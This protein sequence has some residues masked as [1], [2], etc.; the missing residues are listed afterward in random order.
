[1][2][3]TRNMIAEGLRRLGVRPGEVLLL[4]S[5][6]KSLGRV[7]GGPQ[8]LV[9]A[10]QDVLTTEGTLV[11]PTLT[12][13][14]VNA[15][16][17]RFDVRQSASRV[18][19]VTEVFRTMPGVRRSLH[20]THSLAAWGRLRDE[21]LEGHEA[22]TSAGPIGSPYHR[23]VEHGGRILFLG[24]R[25]SS[26]TMMHCVEEW[27]PVPESLTAEMQPLEVVD[28]DGRII[29]SPQHRHA[30]ARSRHYAK[31]APLFEQ[32]G[33]LVTGR[34][35]EAECRLVDSAIMAER[36]LRLLR[37]VDRDLFTHDQLPE[38]A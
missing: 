21:L 3:V 38:G 19:L 2:D 18:G 13:D 4:H 34:V 37:E 12:W 35:A 27:A 36:T 23:I 1:M 31:M 14:T 5:S 30:G 22:C 8:T 17:P 9:A 32:W 10:L 11:M 7:E 6:L 28:Y 25:L 16:H 33:C 29:P 26:N 15:E 24:C 20:P